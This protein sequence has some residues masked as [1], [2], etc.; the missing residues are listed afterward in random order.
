MVENIFYNY[1]KITSGDYVLAD[2][3]VVFGWY[4]I[5]DQIITNKICHQEGF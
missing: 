1:S 4:T 3:V 2:K 5:Y